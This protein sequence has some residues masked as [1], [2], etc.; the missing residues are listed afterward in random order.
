MS[1]NTK[2]LISLDVLRG[3][4]LLGILSM[5]I[6]G[7]AL[8]IGAYNNP[9]AG[10]G[11]GINYWIYNMLHVLSD[12][13]FMNLFAL[14]FG[15]G[16][17]LFRENAL[18]KNKPA[19]CL[20]YRRNFWLLLMGIIHMT[21]IWV[22]DILTAYALVAFFVFFFRNLSP[23]WLIGFGVLFYSVP[24]T[25]S[26]IYQSYIPSLSPETLAPFKELWQP[27]PE[28]VQ[29]ITDQHLGISTAEDSVFEMP[30]AIIWWFVSDMFCRS[31]GMMLFGMALYKME[32]LQALRTNAFYRKMICWGIGIGF[33][34][35]FIGIGLNIYHN[36]DVTYSPAFGRVPNQIGALFTAMGYVGLVMWWVKQN[37]LFSKAKIALA[38]VGRMAFTN[39]IMQSIISNCLFYGWGLGLHGQLERWELLLITIVIWVFQ[40]I[41]STLWLRYFRFGPLE[42]LWRSLTYF[43]FQPILKS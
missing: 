19:T 24:I 40:I 20:H 34:C 31:L 12:Q 29:K 16:V 6:V 30:P 39:Y 15:A 2:R 28:L 37:N 1:A 43:K 42:W 36:Y 22:G 18:R 13:K 38:N 9:M 17:L 4:A 5:N 10:G 33:T 35:S 3:V 41:F 11:E 8:Y 21:C 32:V 26:I 27:T 23:K 25:L 7:S 14:L